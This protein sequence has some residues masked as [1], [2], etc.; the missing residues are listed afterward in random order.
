MSD[1][2][3]EQ[4]ALSYYKAGESQVVGERDWQRPEWVPKRVVLSGIVRGDGPWYSVF[5]QAGEHEVESNQFGAVSTRATN[6][7]MLGLR[8]SEFKVIEWTR[9]PHLTKAE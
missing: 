7:E 9:N 8:L 2:T 1:L 6:G 5:A 3:N 4:K